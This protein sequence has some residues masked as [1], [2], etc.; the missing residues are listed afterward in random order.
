MDNGMDDW[1]DG[2]DEESEEEIR[3]VKKCSLPLRHICFS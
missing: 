3:T 1:M 2:N